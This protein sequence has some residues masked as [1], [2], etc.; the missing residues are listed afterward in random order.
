MLLNYFILYSYY[1]CVDLIPQSLKKKFFLFF[2]YSFN[3]WKKRITKN[4]EIKEE[5]GGGEKKKKIAHIR[6]FTTI[7]LTKIQCSFKIYTFNPPFFLFFHGSLYF[8]G[9]E[10]GELES[11]SKV[12]ARDLTNETNF[13]LP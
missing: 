7:I 8:Q 4:T 11:G 1:S 12:D 5:R 10:I 2:F 6:F 3:H 9:E 13:D